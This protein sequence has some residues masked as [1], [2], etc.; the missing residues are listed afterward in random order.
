MAEGG[1]EIVKNV[2]SSAH[3]TEVQNI[4][5]GLAAIGLSRSYVERKLRMPPGTLVTWEK[6]GPGPG[7]LM[8]L[9]FVFRDPSILKLFPGTV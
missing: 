4:L 2:Y 5:Q 3:R 6:D 9:R 8:L 1:D 7:G